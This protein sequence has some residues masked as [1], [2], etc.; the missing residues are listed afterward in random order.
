M[1]D[2]DDKKP[3]PKIDARWHAVHIGAGPNAC[4]AARTIGKRRFLS[5]DAPRLPLPDCTMPAACKCAYKHHKDR[6]AA[7]RRWTDQGGAARLRT[8]GERRGPRGRRE[9]D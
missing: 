2:K 3:K 5:K 8:Q 6:R 4:P 1:A 9:D 7:P